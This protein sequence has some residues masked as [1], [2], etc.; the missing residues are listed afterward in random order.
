LRFLLLLAFLSSIAFGLAKLCVLTPPS[1]WGKLPSS[2]RIGLFV[3]GGHFDL[4]A[5]RRLTKAFCEFCGRPSKGDG[6]VRTKTW[7]SFY[8]LSYCAAE[9]NGSLDQI[10]KSVVASAYSDASRPQTSRN[11]KAWLG[12][13]DGHLAPLDLN[14][15]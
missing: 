13:W 1:N 5:E 10:A 8:S 4:E 15:P 6:S 9:P 3:Q 7:S 12:S 11:F 2:A 14:C